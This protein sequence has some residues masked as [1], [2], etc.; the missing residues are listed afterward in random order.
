[1]FFFIFVASGAARAQ[2]P[3]DLQESFT[4]PAANCKTMCTS[5]N[6]LQTFTGYKELDAYMVHQ[7]DRLWLQMD[8]T[9]TVVLGV[10]DQCQF[11]GVAQPIQPPIEHSDLNG[12]GPPPH[13]PTICT[14]IPG[15]PTNCN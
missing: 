7:P 14:T 9:R 12:P 13:P 5:L 6:G 4:C 11:E 3:G 2:I 8:K 10:G 15:R 1:L